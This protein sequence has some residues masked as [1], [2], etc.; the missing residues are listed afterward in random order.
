MKRPLVVVA[1]LVC[2][3]I[4]Y[5]ACLRVPFAYTYSA[6]IALLCV[7]LLWGEKKIS[8]C[9]AFLCAAVF[10]CAGAVARDQQTLSSRHFCRY[11]QFQS[12]GYYIFK[13][14]VASEPYVDASKVSFVL[15]VTEIQQDAFWYRCCGNLFVRLRTEGKLEYADT[16]L[17][18]GKVRR[19]CDSLITQGKDLRLFRTPQ[20]HALRCTE[21][22]I[23]KR[24]GLNPRYSFKRVALRFR[25][26]LTRILCRYIPLPAADVMSALVLGERRSIPLALNRAMIKTGTVHILVVS[27]FHV[28]IVT[29]VLIA[30]LQSAQVPRRIRL[31]CVIPALC[32]YCMVVGCA[33]SVVRATVMASIFLCAG[34]FRREAD[35]Y[36]SLAAAAI[37]ILSINPRQIFDIGF[38]LS[39]ASVLSIAYFYPRL[40]S[41]LR[42]RCVKP[43]PLRYFLRACL[44]SASA[45]LGTMGLIAC[46]FRL[47]SPITV[48]ANLFIVPLA[49]LATAAGF[50]VLGVG[51]WCPFLGRS[52]GLASELLIS[53]MLA[54]N[55]MF[56]KIPL[57]YIYLR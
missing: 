48:V 49:S 37:V 33:S 19:A 57:A 32:F 30:T 25:A 22:T 29:A 23:I 12:D 14:Q 46:Y 15:S 8:F 17:I 54:I 35:V 56:I 5:G 4:I 10:L 3:G 1:V 24:R 53:L 41:F 9:D 36:N 40:S 6:A 7:T 31:F 11:L 16:L 55:S 27:G 44:V 34:F 20:D 50:L 2:A 26:R 38:Q 47:F 42:I 52:F 28:G 21:A 45:W 43:R 39:F 18:K 51:A 13:G